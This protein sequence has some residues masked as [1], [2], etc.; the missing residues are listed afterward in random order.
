MMV[1]LVSAF[2]MV[3]LFPLI[4]GAQVQLKICSILGQTPPTA[5]PVCGTDKFVQTTVPICGSKEIP[6]PGCSTR[7][8]VQYYDKNPY[9][10]KFTCYQSGTLGFVIQPNNLGDDYDWQ[11]FDITG[12]NPGDVFTNAAL[13][14]AGN[15]AGTYGLTGASGSAF[16]SIQCASDPVNDV[17]TFSH[18]PNLIKGHNYLLLISHFTDSQ[19]GY[20]LTFGGGT[21]SITDT[22]TPKIKGV[23]VSCDAI[24]LIVTTNK[25][26]K[27][28][29]I[30]ADGTDFI[31]TTGTSLV[32]SASGYNCNNSFDMDSVQL[33][34]DKPLLPGNYLLIAHNG[35]DGNTLL[36]ACGTQIIAGDQLPFTVY[37]PQPTPMDSVAPAGCTPN[38]IHLVFRNRMQCSS[39]AP[40]GSD[41]I[42]HGSTAVNIVSA[43]ANCESGLGNI[44]D[45]TLGSPIYTQGSY[46]VTLVTG[47]DGN[48]IVDECG[49]V[50][51]AGQVVNF[52]TV[53]TVSAQFSTHVLFGCRQDTILVNSLGGPGINQWQWN[54]DSAQ[55][56]DLRSP[57][58]IY[59]EFGDKNIQLI[60]SNGVCSDTSS[61]IVSLDNALHAAF[62]APDL[63]CPSD[64]V[65]IVN[66]STGH[67]SSWNW[68]YGDGTGDMGQLPAEHTYP[69]NPL[70]DQVF[71][72]SLIVEDNL[73][74]K[75]TTAQNVRK[76]HSCYIAVPTAFTPNGDGINDYLYPLNAFK[77]DNLEFRVYN[78]YGQLIFETVDWTKKWDGTLNGKPQVTGTYVWTLRY[79]DRDSGKK[80]FQKGTSVLIR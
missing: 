21:A 79:T 74:C 71:T 50:T 12:R 11:I 67:I 15:W 49:Q 61:A 51:P 72:I 14:V 53:D 63:I 28:S 25:K 64:K 32:I 20:T 46:Q 42:I 33:V 47:T 31:I 1:K 70:A 80:I 44:I 30:A 22:V 40:D 10:Y 6:V 65:S 4:S 9:W 5:F 55:M 23:S 62:E 3:L 35:S 7:G 57:V 36:D 60:V 75:D 43:S 41:F 29:S 16:G 18:W 54:Y 19:S 13:F 52:T 68:D 17:P 69:N 24:K 76:L 34:L 78:R 39:I 2:L 77:A 45:L 27:C 73:G 37:P 8:G 66:S 48:T 26:L 59:T 58:L 38:V 56:S